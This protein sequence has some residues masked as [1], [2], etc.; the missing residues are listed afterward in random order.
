MG[1]MAPHPSPGHLFL[2]VRLP[3]VSI[4]A[5]AHIASISDRIERKLRQPLTC[6]W[7]T[8]YNRPLHQRHAVLLGAGVRM[9]P[10]SQP[11]RQ[12]CTLPPPRKAALVKASIMH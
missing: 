4:L 11:D 10:L 6:R 12:A 8:W 5:S 7:L 1:L 3:G 9:P 2:L